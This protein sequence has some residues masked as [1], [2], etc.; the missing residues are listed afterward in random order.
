[1]HLGDGL[2]HKF[3]I[4][5]GTARKVLRAARAY[6]EL[7]VYDPGRPIAYARTVYL[8]TPDGRYL[9]STDQRSRVRLRMRQY[10]SAPD[11]VEPPV[12]SS[13]TWLELKRT[14]GLERRKIRIAMSAEQAIDLAAGRMSG[15]IAARL[16]A[17]P[18][19]EELADELATGVLRPAVTTWYRRL[20]LA[21]DGLRLTFDE[22]IAFCRPWP[23]VGLGEPAEPAGT[24]MRER[25]TIVE[26]KTVGPTPPPLTGVLRPLEPAP[27]YSKFH[28]AMAV[29]GRAPVKRDGTLPLPVLT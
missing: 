8:D 28:A 15:A 7:E 3:L 6:L 27:Q 16:A 25:R 9:R 2:E 13:P 24:L 11:L 19:L 10:A 5:R 29:A 26:L 22:A 20:S 14:A 1:M 17:E 21:G 4:D 12:V 18:G 23:P